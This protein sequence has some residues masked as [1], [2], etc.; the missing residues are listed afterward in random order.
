M[1]GALYFDLQVDENIFLGMSNVRAWQ[2]FK[3]AMPKLTPQ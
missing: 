2:V 1:D 3:F